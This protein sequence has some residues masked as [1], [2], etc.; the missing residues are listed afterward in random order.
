[1]K[2]LMIVDHPYGLQASENVPHNRS[3]TAAQAA[4]AIRSLTSAGHEVDVIDLVEDGFDPVMRR[5]DLVAWR[6]KTVVDP[7][8]ADYQARLMAAD[9]LVFAFPIWWEAM[10]A[11][12]KGFLDKV[13]TKG[14]V[15]IEPDRPGLFINGIPNVKGVALLTT[16]STPG[17]LYRWLIGN[18][19]LK[20]MFR[21]TFRKIGVKKLRWL[22][23]VN[24]AGKTPEQREANLSRLE[25]EFASAFV[26]EAAVPVH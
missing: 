2:I 5:E 11:L 10:P 3:Y 24:P 17:F 9:Y 1:M 6:L 19:V 7:L 13:L 4:A 15:Y 20:I 18:P 22:N 25:R 8:A 14:V 16:M 12:T 21:G 26:V 23:A